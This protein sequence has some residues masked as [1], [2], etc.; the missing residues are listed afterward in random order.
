[1]QPAH[2]HLADAKVL[3]VEDE[4]LILMDCET[5]LRDIG[6]GHVVGVTTARE[7]LLALDQSP[8][9][10]DVAILDVSLQETSSLALADMLAA[11]GV[12]TGFMSGY[13]IETLPEKFRD[14]PYISKPFVPAQLTAMLAAMLA[15]PAKG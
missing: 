9:G 15:P 12:A 7:A 1:M 6:V 13:A 2:A 14:K 10:F 4:P 3:I 5:I 11:R 8:S